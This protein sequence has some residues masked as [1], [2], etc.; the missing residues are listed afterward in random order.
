MISSVADGW[1]LDVST[2]RY[3]PVGFGSYHWVTVEAGGTPYFI[4]V[5]D[6]RQK[7]WLGA[8]PTAAFGGLRSAFDTAFAL[9]HNGGLEFVVAPV[10]T[11]RGE[12]V[13]RIGKHFAVAIYPM[14]DGTAGSFDEAGTPEERTELIRMLVELHVATPFVESTARFAN[15]ELPGRQSLEN[16][17]HAI[18]RKWLG[19]PLSGPAKAL[20][21]THGDAVARSLTSFD[22]LAERVTSAGAKVVITHGEPHR[23]N[24]LYTNRKLFLV[25]WDTVGL[26][27]PERDLWMLDSAAGHEFDLYAGLSGRPVDMAA[28]DL[29]RTRWALDD[30]ASFVNRLRS[31]HERSPDTEHTLVSLR[32]TLER[33]AGIRP[34]PD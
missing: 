26:A 22:Q 32:T 29:Y 6:L 7:G 20:L 13:R 17:L 31:P 8:T 23:G 15:L 14:V 25:D 30:I 18:G 27:P 21:T 33:S 19:G 34:R 24:V 1:G 10:P 3:A 4:T 28:I 5:D 16:A 11:G 9:R 12:T 2:A